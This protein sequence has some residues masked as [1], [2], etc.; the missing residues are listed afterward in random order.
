MPIRHNGRWYTEEQFKKI[1]QVGIVKKHK[2][3]SLF[4]SKRKNSRRN[5][6]KRHLQTI[7]NQEF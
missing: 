5:M 4:L 1:I 7:L 2:D 3:G 6:D